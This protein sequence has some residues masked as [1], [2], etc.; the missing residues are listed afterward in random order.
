M[1]A[2]VYLNEVNKNNNKV[3][4]A[5][6]RQ[7][8]DDYAKRF[9]IEIVDYYAG[10]EKHKITQNENEYDIVL[11]ERCATLGDKMVEVKPLLAELEK[12]GK[13]LISCTYCWDFMSQNIRNKY[14]AVEKKLM[15]GKETFAKTSVHAR[16]SP[17]YA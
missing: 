11:V 15:A 17:V 4:V 9:G 3:S 1:K 2:I 5:E 12:N 13:A 8:V 7:R 10:N 16:K 14:K 6:Q